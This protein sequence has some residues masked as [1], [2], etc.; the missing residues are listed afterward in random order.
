MYRLRYE[1]LEGKL[2]SNLVMDRKAET[3]Y[4]VVIHRK[5][6]VQFQIMAMDNSI[7]VETAQNVTDA[8]RKAKRKLIELG[9]SFSKEI[10]F[11]KNDQLRK[12]I[13]KATRG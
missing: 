2:C 12:K 9:V 5:P 4:R 3:F 8:K 1:E 7:C 11:K 10:R 13:Y 6:C